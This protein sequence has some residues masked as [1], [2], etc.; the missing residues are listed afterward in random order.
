MEVQPETSCINP[1]LAAFAPFYLLPLPTF[2]LAHCWQLLATLPL[3][4]GFDRVWPPLPPFGLFVPFFL[5][6]LGHVWAISGHLWPRFAIF[7]SQK[8]Q[9]VANQKLKSVAKSQQK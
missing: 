6:A 8:L 3:F 4:V 9:K 5:V 7:G 2:A 1:L